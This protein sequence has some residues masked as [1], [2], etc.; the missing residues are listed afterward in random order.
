MAFFFP[1]Q[2]ILS[3]EDKI[4]TCGPWHVKQHTCTCTC[5]CKHIHTQTVIS[6]YIDKKGN[7]QRQRLTDMEEGAKPYTKRRWP[8]SGWSST[9][10]RW[11]PTP[12]NVGKTPETEATEL[13][14]FLQL[15]GRIWSCWDF[16]QTSGLQ[17]YATF[18][19]LG[20]QFLVL[21]WSRKL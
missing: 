13:D 10:V 14:F 4:F 3:W 12:R 11:H 7:T 19:V 2:L 6:K 18:L 16:V 21:H 9:K 1:K 8:H 15:S 17:N 5:V 20:S